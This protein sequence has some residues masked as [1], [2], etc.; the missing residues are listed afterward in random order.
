M[1]KCPK[2]GKT[3]DDTW[4]IC[5]DCSVSL[6]EDMSIKESNPELRSK[7]RGLLT[8]VNSIAF[9]LYL[10]MGVNLVIFGLDQKHLPII[11]ESLIIASSTFL[12]HKFKSRISAII[13][14]I[15]IVAIVAIHL[16]LGGMMN[17]QLQ[18]IKYWDISLGLSI[19]A[20]WA[21][22]QLR[23]EEKREGKKIP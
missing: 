5:L 22:F 3:Y 14:L 12:F 7:K 13:L 6:T 4:K 2:C 11:I 20:V 9:A 21:S 19:G 23:E 8:T 18:W 16:L 1:R 10:I 15:S 17:I